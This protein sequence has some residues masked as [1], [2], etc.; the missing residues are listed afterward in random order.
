MMSREEMRRQQKQ[1]AAPV[2][3][4]HPHHFWASF[5]GVLLTLIIA[6]GLLLNATVLNADFAA[7]E[8]AD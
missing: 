8:L 5:L 4:P 1:T 7:D 2:K 6:V 3:K